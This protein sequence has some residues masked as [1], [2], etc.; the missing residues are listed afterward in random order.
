MA[1]CGANETTGRVGGREEVVARKV[2]VLPG[3]GIGPEVTEP[4]VGVLRAASRLLDLSVEVTWG[5]LGGV[6]ID[7]FGSALPEKTRREA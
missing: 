5:K 1:A 6:T 7:A 2:L 3:D 4:A